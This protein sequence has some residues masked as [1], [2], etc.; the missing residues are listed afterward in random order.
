MEKMSLEETLKLLYNVLYYEPDSASKFAAS[1]PPIITILNNIVLPSPTLQP[2]VTLLINALMNL[3]LDLTAPESSLGNPVFPDSDSRGLIDR[4]IHILDLSLK[5]S[6][7]RE[8]DQ[9]LS[10]LITLLRRIHE[11]APEQTKSHLR[12][13]LLPSK[14][15]R[16]KPIGQDETLPSRLLRLTNSPLLPMLRDSVSAFFFEM[17]DKDASTFIQNIGYGYAAGFLSM[18]KIA[19]PESAMGGASVSDDG[20]RVGVDKTSFGPRTGAGLGPRSGSGFVN[21]VTGQRRDAEPEDMG[22]EM[23]DEEKEREAERLFVLF[24]RLRL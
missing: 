9:T 24:E 1:L 4:L 8:L 12:S 2:P 18:N 10:P 6:P 21:P 5:S 7:T 17:S 19:V 16:D 11:I 23:T 22:P 14:E 13:L 15:N 3:E 20:D